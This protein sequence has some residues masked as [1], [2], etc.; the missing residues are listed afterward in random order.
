MAW[1]AAWRMSCCKTPAQQESETIGHGLTSGEG[2]D[3]RNR[4]SPDADTPQKGKSRL[5]SDAALVHL[6]SPKSM[7]GTETTGMPTARSLAGQLSDSEGEDVPDDFRP[8]GAPMAKYTGTYELNDWRFQVTLD[9]KKI[10]FDPYGRV[11][12]EVMYRCMRAPGGQDGLDGRSGVE[13]FEG[14]WAAETRTILARGVRVSDTEL[15][16]VNSSFAFFFDDSCVRG[17]I[18]G[19]WIQLPVEKRLPVLKL[20]TQGQDEPGPAAPP[21]AP[22]QAAGGRQRP[23][24]LALST[25]AEKR[26]VHAA[27]PVPGLNLL[28]AMGV[29]FGGGADDDTARSAQLRLDKVEQI[30]VLAPGRRSL[31]QQDADSLTVVGAVRPSAPVVP[32]LSLPP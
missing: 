24:P 8:K 6:E 27:S 17:S 29:E 2:Q 12:G 1:P 14:R 28:A 19:N 22:A 23:S 30:G 21:E 3:P 9:C 4:Q 5:R 26:T 10:F 15:L 18:G 16:R 31:L 7:P 11:T 32:L 13:S 25:Q 20:P